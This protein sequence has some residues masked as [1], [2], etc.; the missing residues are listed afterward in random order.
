M[1][2]RFSASARKLRVR[3]LSTV[4]IVCGPPPKARM[5]G[6]VFAGSYPMGRTTLY[7]TVVPPT[8]LVFSSN[9]AWTGRVA[10]IATTIAAENS[11][12]HF[13]LACFI[14]GTPCFEHGNIDFTQD[15]QSSARR[16]SVFPDLFGGPLMRTSPGGAR[17]MD[18]SST[19][20]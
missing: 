17:Y 11:G 19:P 18:T 15:F 2:P 9:S 4:F 5:A 13:D 7:R 14:S 8:F 16:P 1:Y 6:Y 3:T 12:I 20:L 10:N